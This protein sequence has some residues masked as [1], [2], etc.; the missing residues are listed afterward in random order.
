MT[1]ATYFAVV[2][3]RLA[4]TAV[5]EERVTIGGVTMRM[6]RMAG[7]GAGQWDSHSNTE[8]TAMAWSDDF[9][10]ECRDH[11]LWICCA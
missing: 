3:T 9:Q 4:E 6:V 8:D 2:F 11:T 1:D 10:V 5:A 7:G